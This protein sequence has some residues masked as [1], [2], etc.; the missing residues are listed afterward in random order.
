MMWTLGCIGPVETRR[1]IA[2]EID[3][4]ISDSNSARTLELGRFTNNVAGELARLDRDGVAEVL[5]G[6]GL[7]D[8][9]A[10]SDGCGGFP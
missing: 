3:R 2:S 4:Q 6:E 7:P 8:G 5:F 9:R 10:R 1:L